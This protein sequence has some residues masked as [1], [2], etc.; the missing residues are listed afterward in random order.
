[1]CTG[2]CAQGCVCTGEGR[3]GR[4]GEGRTIAKASRTLNKH[5][6]MQCFPTFS[7]S[8]LGTERNVCMTFSWR[9]DDMM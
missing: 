5:C 6:S 8:P 4:G 3:G 2:M 9:R 7:S 1:M